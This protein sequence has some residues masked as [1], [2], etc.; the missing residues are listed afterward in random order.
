MKV[1]KLALRMLTFY[2][3]FNGTGILG[4]E[5]LNLCVCH[6]SLFEGGSW[7]RMRASFSGITHFILK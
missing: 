6:Y 2:M 7:S 3:C 4:D 1:V 5:T